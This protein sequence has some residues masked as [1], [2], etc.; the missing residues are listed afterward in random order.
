MS[1]RAAAWLA[2]SLWGFGLAIG[3]LGHLLDAWNDHL[4]SMVASS[5]LALLA[6]LTVGAL[7][8]WRRPANRIG[9]LFLLSTL[10]LAFGGARNLADQYAIYTLVTHPGALPGGAWAVLLGQIAQIA[11]FFSLVSLVLL[12]FPD[13]RPLS[14][15]WRIVAWAAGLFIALAVV[16]ELLNPLPS[17]ADELYVANPLAPG[18]A[19][20]A[21]IAAHTLSALAQT[22]TT[23]TGLAIA[24][25]SVT[26]ALLRFRRARGD[27]RQQLKWF[28]Y[29]VLLI[30]VSLVVGMIA[31]LLNLTWLNDL[32]WWQI[33]IVGIPIAVA[34]AILKYRLYAI[35]LLIRR[36]LIYGLLTA[37]LALSYLGAVVA[38]QTIFTVFTGSARSEWVT[39]PSTLFIAALFVPLRNRLQRFIDQRFYRRKYDAARTLAEFGAAVRDEVNLDQLVDHLARVV[40]DTMQPESVGLLILPSPAPPAA[41]PAEAGPE[42]P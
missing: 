3:L 18:L 31:S 29:G 37:L 39:V 19:R 10:L 27:E 4:N 16:S 5:D 13:G 17:T 12:L 24:F 15:R 42:R 14:P 34:I 35:D 11:G 30:P 21:P 1:Q 40:D 32:G 23:V 33:S 2:W 28:A 8:V 22:L 20:A 36:T 7:I 38:L 25:A 41:P 26:S 6:Y 9:W